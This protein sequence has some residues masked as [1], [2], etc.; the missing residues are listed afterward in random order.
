MHLVELLERAERCNKEIGL[1]YFNAYSGRQ[2]QL[3][4]SSILD[5]YPE[6]Y[7]RETLRHVED[8][9]TEE[10]ADDR[11]RRFLRMAFTTNYFNGQLKNYTDRLANIESSAVVEANG[12]RITYRALPVVLSNERDYERR[13]R[14]DDAYIAAL[15]QMNPLREEAQELSRTLTHDLGYRNFIDLAEQVAGMRIYPMRDLLKKF[16]GETAGVYEEQLGRYA[17]AT[18]GLSRESMRHADIGFLMRAGRF[19]EMFPREDLVPALAR[20]LSGLG[21]DLYNQPNVTLDLEVRAKKTPRAF[22]IGIDAP[23]DVRLVLQPRGGQDDFATLFHEA[24]HLEFGAHMSAGQPFIYRRYGDN[25]VHESYAFL[26]Q[27]LVDDPVWWRLIMGNGDAAEY[28][29]FARFQRLYLLRRYAGKL[30]YEVEFYEGDGGPQFG[31]TYA[32]KLGQACG[33][34]YPP[35]RYLQDLDFGFY[36]LQYLQAWIWECQMRSLLKRDFGEDWFTKR[37]A[38][39]F[40]RDLWSEGQKYDVWELAGRLGF[41]GLDIGLLQEEL[42]QG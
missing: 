35:E 29:R 15:A 30:D 39:D 17:A 11:E 13:G 25:S 24:G 10:V 27:H 23:R 26:L 12:Q 5:K 14:L 37:K 8:L 31:D 38:G 7:S 3:N 34:A 40:L 22:C 41:E 16:L 19:D 32:G 1:E 20:T 21:I 33:F 36:V 4:I 18:P 6:L 9:S 42:T 2:D 28:I